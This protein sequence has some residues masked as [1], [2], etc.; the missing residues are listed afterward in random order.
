MN[1][2]SFTFDTLHFRANSSKYE[3]ECIQKQNTN[4]PIVP[5]SKA[6][7]PTETLLEK[8]LLKDV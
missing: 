4:V 8:P 7:N 2:G 1:L 5:M 3:F 6:I